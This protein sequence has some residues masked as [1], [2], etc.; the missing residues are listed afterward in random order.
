M[1]VPL[2][3]SAQKLHGELV[4]WDAVFLGR[5]LSIVDANT[6]YRLTLR[7]ETYI[8]PTPFGEVVVLGP[9]GRLRA[10]KSPYRRI[11][12]D[13]AL[14]YAYLALAIRQLQDLGYVYIERE[15]PTRH[16]LRGS[17]MRRCL[18][19]GQARGMAS[20]TLRGLLTKREV[21]LLRTGRRLLVVVPDLR[22]IRHFHAKHATLVRIHLLRIPKDTGVQ[23]LA[24]QEAVRRAR[25]RELDLAGW[26][27]RKAKIASSPTAPEPGEVS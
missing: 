27:R 15:S 10:K 11:T 12:T 4:C 25:K 16:W 9:E 8:Q 24:E 18:V 13:P 5:A 21:D 14:N 3:E 19:I 17:D 26:H 23:F 20:R 7:G 22:T 2:S 1:K 6:L